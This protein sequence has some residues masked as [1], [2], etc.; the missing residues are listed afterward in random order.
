MLDRAQILQKLTQ[1]KPRY[2]EEGVI[3]LGLFGSY[4]HKSQTKFSDL[5][6]LYS[7]DYDK[8]SQKYKDGFSKLLKIESIKEELEDVFQVKVDL[9]PDTN[10]T[11]LKDFIHV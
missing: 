1:I 11:L 8:F 4:A 5:D 2:E 3:L 10:K 7:L 9:V 6:L